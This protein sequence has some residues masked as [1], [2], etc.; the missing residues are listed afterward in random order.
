MS[1]VAVIAEFHPYHNGHHYLLEQAM[2]LSHADH[3]V[4]LM[5]GNFLQRGSIALWDKY[6]RAEMAVA[7]GFDLCLELPFVYATGSAGDFADGAVAIL[8]KLQ[9]VDSLAFGVEQAEPEMF[10]QI[11][12][13]LTGEPENYQ[14]ALKQALK[15]GASYPKARQTA[16]AAICGDSAAALLETPNNTLALSYLCAIKKLHANI[17]P[18]FIKRISN[19]YHDTDLQAQ[20]S[21]ATAIRTALTEGTDFSELASQVPPTTYCR[22]NTPTRSYL[23]DAMLTPFVQACRLREPTLSDICDISPTLAD[24]LQ[25]APYP[26]DYEALVEQLK[27]KNI[28]RSRIARALLHLLL[29]YTESDR[30]A[31]IR[32]GYGFYANILA[33]KKE[34][35]KLVRLL[36]DCSEIPIITKKADFESILAEY[37]A[38]ASPQDKA[39]YT[40][41]AHTMW[42]Y[43]LRAT[44]LY[45]CICFN[46][47]GIT[48]PNDYT[49]KLP[50]L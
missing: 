27:T 37:A 21:S 25:R 40:S 45:N 7:D 4:A 10:E 44:E 18:I 20:I 48:L 22:M 36:H 29:G 39:A 1:I 19:D 11:A 31:F 15:N 24:K 8:N 26:I 13:I 46:Q 50:V 2:S 35:S 43:D 34:S 16:I 6:T 41:L 23:S 47:Y 3:A 5:S 17:K 14:L 33:L 42:Q 9:T 30:Q 28:T 12:E 32:H 38:T 49:R